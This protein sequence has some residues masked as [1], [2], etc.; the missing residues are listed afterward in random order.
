MSF[1]LRKIVGSSLCLGCGLCE[2]LARRDGVRMR[3]AENGFY[4][5]VSQNRIAKATQTELKKL[6][7][8][9]RLDCIDTRETFC[10]PVKAAYEGWAGP[11]IRISAG[12]ARRAESSPRWR[13]TCSVR[14]RR[15]GYCK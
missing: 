4:E 15:P 13:S 6:C 1:K 2:A 9:I 8:G 5:P 7:P 11:A 3:L 10:G 12:P 14:N